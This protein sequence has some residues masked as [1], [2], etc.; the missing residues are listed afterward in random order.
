MQVGLERARIVLTTVAQGKGQQQSTPIK[1]AQDPQQSGTFTELARI[2]RRRSQESSASWCHP[3]D[4]GSFPGGGGPIG[5]SISRRV[6]ETVD[7]E[8][9]DVSD[10]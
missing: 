5:L 9:F 7:P 10:V 8:E 3:D 2:W 1:F 6:P 4:R